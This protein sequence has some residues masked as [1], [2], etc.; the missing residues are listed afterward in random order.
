[1]HRMM[2]YHTITNN[3]IV[4]KILSS[5]QKLTLSHD[6]RLPITISI[7]KALPK[8]LDC[9]LPSIYDRHLYHAMFIMVFFALLRVGEFTT[10][11]FGSANVIQYGQVELVNNNE[12]L[13]NIVLHMSHTFRISGASHAH[14]NNFS[15]TQL[16]RLGHWNSSAYTKYICCPALAVNSFT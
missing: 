8:A 1:M 11:Q 13:S 5:A 9:I 10:T 12:G 2:G 14:Q 16:K 7:L 4:K 3:F 15:D 6:R